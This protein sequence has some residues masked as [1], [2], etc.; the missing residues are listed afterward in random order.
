MNHGLCS[1][2]RS[3]VLALVLAAGCVSLHLDVTFAPGSIDMRSHGTTVL[4]E[5]AQRPVHVGDGGTDA[6]SI[7]AEYRLAHPSHGR[8]WRV[9]VDR[10]PG[11]AELEATIESLARVDNPWGCYAEAVLNDRPVGRL[12]A[13]RGAAAGAV[14]VVK[15]LLPAGAL[16]VGENRLAIVQRECAVTRDQDRFDDA[17]IRSVLLRVP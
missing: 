4:Q 10:P 5:P 14:S 11:A 7:P 1:S 13:P 8:G 12:Q 15:V 6:D 2:G 17:L 3:A 9:V 16:Q